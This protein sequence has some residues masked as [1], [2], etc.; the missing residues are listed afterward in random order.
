MQPSLTVALRFQEA[1]NVVRW[2]P[3]GKYC[4]S[5]SDDKTA[6]VW[7]TDS[8]SPLSRLTGHTD[9]VQSL[10]W[11]PPV[12]EVNTRPTL[13]TCVLRLNGVSLSEMLI[14]PKFRMSEDGTIRHWNIKRG[15]CIR[16][17]QKELPAILH[18]LDVHP[19]G[20]YLATS[21]LNAQSEASAEVYS[22]KVRIFEI[23][24]LRDFY[25]F[26]GNREMEL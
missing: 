24:R 11:G 9:G 16:V 20:L 8:S 21:A 26:L 1:I 2:D 3:S 14:K 25:A 4:A 22:A 12:S 5:G 10:S 13:F 18:C 19:S 6:A 15:D 7:T 17:I 23:H